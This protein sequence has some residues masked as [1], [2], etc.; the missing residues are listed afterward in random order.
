[1]GTMSGTD[2]VCNQNRYSWKHGPRSVSTLQ[3]AQNFLN[4]QTSEIERWT[5]FWI[6]P[7]TGNYEAIYSDSVLQD[8]VLGNVAEI[9]AEP[10]VPEVAPPA[11]DEGGPPI[12][13][14]PPTY[15]EKTVPASR[16]FRGVRK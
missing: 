10:Q 1:M 4:N 13:G 7:F 16:E 14:G 9:Y 12:E 6:S 15:I 5:F 2:I 11:Y 8:Q 3:Q